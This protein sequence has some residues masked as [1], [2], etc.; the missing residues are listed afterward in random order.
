MP[1]RKKEVC[2]LNGTLDG[3]LEALI[4]LPGKEHA[5]S[6]ILAVLS[7]PILSALLPASQILKKFH[8]E[9]KSIEDIQNINIISICMCKKKAKQKNNK[10]T[11]TSKCLQYG[12]SDNII[13]IYSSSG[14]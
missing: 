4:G 11:T 12:T 8:Q 6:W 2:G 3:K 14:S 7:R 10:K 13:S 1:S 5:C 9:L